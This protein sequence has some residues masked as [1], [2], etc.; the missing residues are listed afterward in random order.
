MMKNFTELVAF[1]SG[2]GRTRKKDVERRGKEIEYI[3]IFAPREHG[4]GFDTI[5]RFN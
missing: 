1:L 5:C 4:I 3:Y 2:R